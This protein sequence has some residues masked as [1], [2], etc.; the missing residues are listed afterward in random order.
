[1][2]HRG[3]ILEVDCTSSSRIIWGLSCQMSARTAPVM[4]KAKGFHILKWP[5]VNGGW[6]NGTTGP[7]NAHISMISLLKK[8]EN[9]CVA[10][11]ARN[12]FSEGASWR[13][14]AR[15]FEVWGRQIWKSK[16]HPLTPYFYTIFG[17]FRPR[18]WYIWK[19]FLKLFLF[20]ERNWQFLTI[21]P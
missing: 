13:F 5:S 14:G 18:I 8:R 20:L 11:A 12:Y 16:R 9:Y 4:K 3:C 7:N 1:M 6:H 21:F 15:Q 2:G 10:S 19:I 17:R